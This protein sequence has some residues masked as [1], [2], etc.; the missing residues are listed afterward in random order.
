M[1]SDT[2]IG[3]DVPKR[4]LVLCPYPEGVAAGQRLKYEQYFGDWRVHG[5]EVVTSPFIDRPTWEILYKPGHLFTKALGLLK[6]YGRRVRD[7]VRLG[8]FDA[9]YV[10]MWC[11]PL[12]PGL[13][14]RLMRRLARRVIYDL[15]DNVLAGAGGGASNPNRLSAL[16]KSSDKPRYLIRSG[17]HVITSSPALNDICLEM[18]QA[19]ACTYISSSVDTDRYE[20][21]DGHS[22]PVTIGWTG[23]FSSKVYL[24]L[25]QGAFQRLAKT[26][27]F[28]LRVIGN[29]DYEL[30]G[31][32]LEVVQWTSANEIR[33]LQAFDIGVY[34]LPVDDWVLGKSGL[35]AIQ[36]MA[37]GIPTVATSVGT[38]PMIIRNGENGLLVTTEDEW[39]QA[40]STL[41]TDGPLRK[42]MGAQARRDAEAKYSLKAIASLYRDVL[43][44]T[45]GRTY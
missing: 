7:V 20:P 3:R 15:E 1:T 26:H 17:D 43:D 23:T 25:L 18:N 16:F 11:T 12:G 44:A 33:D 42:A 41:L 21:K 5:Y 36:Y 37:M 30:P 6:G 28:R 22:D 27:R 31:V 8:K 40:L 45:V 32:D 38:T 34:P 2:K 29:F 35:K 24:D 14:E 4:I 13:Y 19:R 39:V 10:F 9:I